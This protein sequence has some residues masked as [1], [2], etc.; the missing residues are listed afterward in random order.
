VPWFEFFDGPDAE[1]FH[2]SGDLSAE[3]VDGTIHAGFASR[4]QAVELGTADESETGAEGQRG[5]YVGAVHD[6][7]V[8]VDFDIVADLARHLGQ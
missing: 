8:E 2:G 5:D 6:A 3:D 1:Q 7:G 4:H